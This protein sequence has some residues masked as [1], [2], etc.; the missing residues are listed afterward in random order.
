VPNDVG[1]G[2]GKDAKHGCLIVSGPNMGGKSRSDVIIYRP[3]NR[4]SSAQTLL[5]MLFVSFCSYVRMV[6]LLSIMGQ[7]G[8]YVPAESASLSIL[9]GKNSTGL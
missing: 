3:M 4:V 8:S 1:L 6:A 7:L 2:V 9:D 5:F